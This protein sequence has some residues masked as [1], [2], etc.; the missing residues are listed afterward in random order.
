MA[1]GNQNGAAIADPSNG[2]TFTD[3]DN[4]DVTT[5]GFIRLPVCSPAMAYA[6]WSQ[7]GGP[8]TEVDNYPCIGPQLLGFCDESDFVDK[9]SAASPLVSDCEQLMRNLQAGAATDR[10]DF[11]IENAFGLQHAISNS[12][13]CIF[14]VQGIDKNGNGDFHV[15]AQDIVD[16]ITDS[17]KKFGSSGRV[18]ASGGM[19]CRGTVK[20]QWVEWGLY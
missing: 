9:T 2:A 3:L 16:I 20:P 12:G 17:I 11:L 13:T 10:G 7:M 6:A 8:S 4:Q 14:G 1:N 18:G 15:G 19:F 5:P